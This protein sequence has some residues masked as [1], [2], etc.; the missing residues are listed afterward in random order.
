MFYEE[1]RHLEEEDIGFDTPIYNITLYDKSFLISV[2]KER[3]LVQKKNTYYFPIYLLHQFV[4]QTQIG[5]FEFE[6]SKDTME[7]RIKPF[8]DSSGDL[9]L[10]RLGDPVLYSFANFDY[11]NDITLDVTPMVLKELEAKY[12]HDKAENKEAKVDEE[13]EEEL[14][15]EEPRPFELTTDDIRP[16]ESQVKT[17][18]VLKEGVFTINKTTKRIQMLPE[19]TK[20]SSQKNKE[21][22]S[23]SKDGAPWVEK[24]MKNNRYDIVETEDNGNCLF[25]TVRLAYEQMGYETTVAKLRA[26]VAKEVTKE[27]FDEYRELY[28]STVAEITDTDKKLRE[29][30]AENKNLKE[31]LKAVSATDKLK[32]NDIIKQAN[33]VSAQH[34]E[35]KEKQIVNREFLEEFSHLKN[36][37]SLDKFR[38]YIQ[39]P[40]YWA[41]DWALD[42]LERELNMKF[43]IFSEQDYDED[44]ENNVIRCSISSQDGKTEFSPDFYVMTTYSGNHYRLISYTSKRI[45]TFREIPYDVKTMIVIKCMERNSGLFSQIPEFRA[46]KTKLGVPDEGSEEEEEVEREISGGGQRDSDKSTVFVFYNKS[47]SKNKP[48]KAA[49]EKI[50]SDK[51]HD[52]TGLALPSN[53]DWRKKLDDEWASTFTLDGKKWRT[54]EHYYQASKFKKHNPHFYNQFSLDDGSSEI[55]KDVE[56]ARAA[57]S[58]KGVYKKGKKQIPIRSPDIRIDPDFYGS[59]KNEE[60]ERAIYAKFSQNN[61]LKRVLILTKNAVLKQ[62]VP[63]RPAE[64]DHILMKV[65]QKLQLEN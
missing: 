33:L 38:E 14:A 27:K 62:F 35:L 3:R 63:K 60:R 51:I 53:R 7:E 11:F 5:A 22:Y 58:Q 36:I 45:F 49:N 52:Y 59:R 56:L 30:I 46:F 55:A 20:E 19:E 18:K 8:L 37:N 57:G 34:R 25:D 10:N 1:N 31:R 4:V 15:E 29:L 44:D 32:R 40:A 28:Q 23:G 39:T 54:V 2:G 17:A 61:E 26:L 16:T 6:S 24:Y 50:S 48:G 65:R 42:V 43:I 9:D 64:T 13:E 12:I 21:E 41:D 47:G